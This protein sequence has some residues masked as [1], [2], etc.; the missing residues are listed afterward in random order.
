MTNPLIEEVRAARA[1]LAAE[2]GYDIHRITEWARQRTEA[3]KAATRQPRA[4]KALET[5][6]GASKSP[7][8]RKRRVRPAGVSA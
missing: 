8:V 2:H 4:N 7:V 1:S 5:T 3:L 6:G